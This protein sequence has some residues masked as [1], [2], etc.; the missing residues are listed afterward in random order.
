MAINFGDDDDDQEPN[1][2][3]STSLFS[4]RLKVRTCGL[5]YGL[6][7]SQNYHDCVPESVSGSF[8]WC[9]VRLSAWLLQ[10][11]KREA[12]V[13]TRQLEALKSQ[14]RNK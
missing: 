9:D 11:L 6:I 14:V 12:G 4:Q 1:T 8:E 13:K 3:H 10:E 2:E 7:F 5:F